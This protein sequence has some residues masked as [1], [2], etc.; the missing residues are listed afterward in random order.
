MMP[1]P[2][3]TGLQNCLHRMFSTKAEQQIPRFAQDDASTPV[4]SYFFPSFGISD[5][6]NSALAPKCAGTGAS[7]ASLR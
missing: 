6:L 7:S 2:L 5:V 1:V 3:R 4:P